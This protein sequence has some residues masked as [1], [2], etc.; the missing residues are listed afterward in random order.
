MCTI[1]Q[2]DPLLVLVNTPQ[3]AMHA[4]N[5][6]EIELFEEGLSKNLEKVNAFFLLKPVTFLRMA[7]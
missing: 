6:F 3:K 5:S 7:L 4:R 1:S 2:S